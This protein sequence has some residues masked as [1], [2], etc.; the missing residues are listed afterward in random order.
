MIEHDK[1]DCPKVTVIVPFLNAETTLERCARSVL[2]Q[3]LEKLEVV[4][5]NDG[6]HDRS[7]DVIRTVLSDY[8]SKAANVKLL[9][10][11]TRHGVHYAHN[12]AI[13][14][15]TGCY[16][17]RCDADDEFA[18]PDA[19]RLMVEAAER[20]KA[21][22]V[23]APY[24][25][26]KGEKRLFMRLPEAF[27]DI[28]AMRINTAGYS[29]CNKLISRSL[30]VDNGISLFSKVDCWEDLGLVARILALTDKVATIDTP[31]YNYYLNPKERS[32]SRSSR[33]TLLHQHL[34]A[35][36]M[37]EQW[38]AKE[39]PDNRYERFLTRLKFISKVKFL[40]GKDKDVSAW[41]KTFPE[42]NSRVLSI[43]GVPLIYKLMYAAVAAMPTK[44][45]QWVADRCNI[46][47]RD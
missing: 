31:V 11:P 46:F 13:F 20:E 18:T 29:L 3:T 44:L 33:D 8:P 30:V 39:F 26:I 7:L 47:Y 1:S 5:V 32:L 23:A 34:L 12:A 27:P 37:L 15:A 16:L 25:M 40:R 9:D 10:F 35:A 22:V 38:F 21:D 19:L 28:N 36:L 42:V 2:S 6:S 45:C 24:I 41:K 43:T 14:K 17:I 4:F